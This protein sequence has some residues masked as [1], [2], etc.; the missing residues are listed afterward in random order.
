MRTLKSEFPGLAVPAR[1]FRT[2]EQKAG[3]EAEEER[4]ARVAMHTLARQMMDVKRWRQLG[5][6]NPEIYRWGLENLVRAI[7][8]VMNRYCGFEANRPKEEQERDDLIAEM[9]WSKGWSFA[10]IAREYNKGNV[11]KPLTPSHV[12]LIC[13][14]HAASQTEQLIRFLRPDLDLEP[15]LRTF[16]L[17]LFECPHCLRDRYKPRRFRELHSTDASDELDAD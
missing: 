9:R 12:G 7:R 17:P 8:T 14:R 4:A 1:A 10:R 11:E 16:N 6:T 15:I 3:R 13:T 2:V 5:E